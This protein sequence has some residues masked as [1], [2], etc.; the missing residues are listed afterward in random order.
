MSYGGA[1]LREW[2]Q[3]AATPIDRILQGARPAELPAER[4]TKFTLTINLKTAK[5]FDLTIPLT[6][7][8]RVD[9]VI[10]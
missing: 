8:A 4:P 10:Q 5:A 3:R 7:L 6:V 1:N 2:Q 9:E